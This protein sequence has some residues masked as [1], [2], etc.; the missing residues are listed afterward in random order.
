[1][2][3]QSL[4]DVC[5]QAFIDGMHPKLQEG[6]RA[7]IDPICLTELERFTKLNLLIQMVHPS[8]VD[9]VARGVTIDYQQLDGW[10]D[11]ILE[12][13]RERCKEPNTTGRVILSPSLQ[14]YLNWNPNKIKCRD[15]C[16]TEEEYDGFISGKLMGHTK[17]TKVSRKKWHIRMDSFVHLAVW[18]EA[19]MDS[20]GTFMLI[21]DEVSHTYKLPGRL[22]GSSCSDLRIV[23]RGDRIR[24][25]D[26]TNREAWAECVLPEELQDDLQKEKTRNKRKH[27]N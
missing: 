8:L 17:F 14:N 10:K 24:I 13:N 25:D 9:S 5:A 20:N 1:M 12:M 23:L 2:N 19:G 21:W 6:A 27:T 11:D 7:S 15:S 26:M 18:F 22:S 16:Y 3:I 4:R